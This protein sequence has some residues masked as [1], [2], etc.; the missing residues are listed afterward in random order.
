[1]TY[2][3]PSKLIS[4]ICIQNRFVFRI[5]EAICVFFFISFLWHKI[6]EN[7][8][9]K[10]YFLY[11]FFQIIERWGKL[12]V[13][14]LSTSQNTC[15]WIIRQ[16]FPSCRGSWCFE[17]SSVT[18]LSVKKLFNSY[19]SLKTKRTF[20]CVCLDFEHVFVDFKKS[21]LCCE[22]KHLRD[23]Q[24]YSKFQNERYFP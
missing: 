3:L 11:F 17:R 7:T 22:N 14:T 24:I 5:K 4:K 19:G 18:C 15:I 23:S 2:L 10:V 20:G 16:L 12:M 13:R 6:V 21:V 1:M 8:T 9:I